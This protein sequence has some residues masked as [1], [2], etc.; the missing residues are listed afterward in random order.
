MRDRTFIAM[1]IGI[2]LTVAAFSASA[3]QEKVESTD[4]AHLIVKLGAEVESKIEKEW[5][6]VEK[7]EE[8]TWSY[9]ISPPFPSKWPMG[10]SWARATAAP[11]AHRQRA[12]RADAPVPRRRKSGI[13]RSILASSSEHNVG[14][15]GSA[16][17]IGF[18]VTSRARV[19]AHH[20]SEG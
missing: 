6:G 18:Y 19:R 7:G 2:S 4:D 9:R 20:P 10:P 11:P 16:E 17:R 3:F 14:R 8:I 12:S 1:F 5:K 15:V 13:S